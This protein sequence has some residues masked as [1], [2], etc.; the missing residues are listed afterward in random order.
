MDDKDSLYRTLVRLAGKD[1]T[2]ITLV[3]PATNFPQIVFAK[4]NVHIPRWLLDKPI[5][6]RFNAKVNINAERP[7]HVMLWD[8][9][10]DTRTPAEQTAHVYKVLGI[11]GATS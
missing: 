10:H 2:T 9:E 6:Y 5:G 7:E 1:D 8:C 3:I 4:D 11:G